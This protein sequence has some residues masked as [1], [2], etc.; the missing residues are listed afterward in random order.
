MLL[1]VAVARR[2]TRRK[3]EVERGASAVETALIAPLF[4]LFLFAIIEFG[5]FLFNTNQVSN[6]SRD[7]AREASTW[8]AAPLADY[9]I[10]RRANKSLGSM[11]ARIDAVIVFKA[12]GANSKVPAACVAAIATTSRG[13]PDLCNIYRPTDLRSLDG[14]NFGWSDLNTVAENA[15]KWDEAWPATKRVE[16]I[17]GAVD[18]DWVGVYV[19]A[20]HKSLTGVIP[21][22]KIY[23]TSIAQIEPQRAG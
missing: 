5:V 23:K 18:P 8:A 21:P 2:V 10:L 19:Q 16:E 11:A 15:G 9:N 17:T 14:T 3:N 13:I 6:A 1:I 12:D 4:F 20:N 7:G 22:R